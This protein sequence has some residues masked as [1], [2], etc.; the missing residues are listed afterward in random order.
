MRKHE[1]RKI[2]AFELWCW[3]RVLRVSWMERKTNMDNREHQTGMDTGVKGAK[4]CFGHVVRAGG[5]ED[6]VMLGR[7]NGARR[8]GRPR[9]RWLDTLM[10]YSS[11]ATIS[12][13]RR[14]AR[15]RAGCRGAATYGCRQE[16]DATRRHKI[17]R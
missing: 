2:D 9:R 14:Y 11:G 7:M 12:N 15:D 10:G 13:M 6:D 1:R 5:M 3:R 17:T 16:S 8:R 4:G